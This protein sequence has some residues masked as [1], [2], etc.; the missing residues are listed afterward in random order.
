MEF[1]V[2]L[3]TE[4]VISETETSLSRKW[5]ALVADSDTQP[6]KLV[7]QYRPLL[8]TVAVTVVSIRAVVHCVP[9]TQQTRVKSVNT[10][11]KFGKVSFFLLV[12]PMLT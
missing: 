8:S 5:I 9:V 12:T 10:D 6:L 11:K 3:D 4:Q 1:N 2:P 7:Y